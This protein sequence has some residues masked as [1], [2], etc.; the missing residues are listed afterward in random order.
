[1]RCHRG[2]IDNGGCQSLQ[3]YSIHMIDLQSIK[4]LIRTRFSGLAR[5]IDTSHPFT[6]K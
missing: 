4:F 6:L 5:Q 2:A 3:I 1:M